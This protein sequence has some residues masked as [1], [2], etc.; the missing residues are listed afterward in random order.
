[1][2]YTVIIMGR[3]EFATDR[4]IQQATKV[5]AHLLETRYKNDVLYKDAPEL[6]NTETRSLVAPRQKFTCSEKVWLNTLHLLEQAT[7]FS[8]AG[9]LN[10]W[11]ILEGTLKEH[12]LLEPQSDKRI[13]KAYQKGRE[14]LA[15]NKFDE[16]RAALT[17]AIDQFPRHAKALERRGYAHYEQKNK[18]AA[19][20]DYAASLAVD[21]KRPD[22]YIGRGRILMDEEK[23][24][25]A[26]LDFTEAMKRSMPHHHAYLEALHRKGACLTEMGEYEQAVKSFDF[27]LGRPLL[28]D[29]PQFLF[30]R[31]VA[32]DKGRALAA[33]GDLKAAIVSF[34]AAL[35][36]PGR[37]G[38]PD[39]GEILLHRGLAAKQ[40]GQAGFIDDWTQAAD[41]GSKRA[42]ELLAEV[43]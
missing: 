34:D 15:N 43:A 17:D 37:D 33:K 16:A 25:D 28:E 21:S 14:L 22:A 18:E 3:L 38:K 5:I 42:A 23:W 20:A 35:E 7:G 39:K 40:N 19:L 10:M 12:Q 24:A 11:R 26:L 29:H 31:R 2:E 36:M 27:F 6:L 13:V 30:R 9:D 1:M 8:I 4:S 41:H 32:F